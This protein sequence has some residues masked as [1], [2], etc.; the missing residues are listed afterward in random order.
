MVTDEDTGM[1]MIAPS[2]SAS[3]VGDPG[4]TSSQL[5]IIIA[6]GYDGPLC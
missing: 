1:N 4:T 3:F 5:H 2:R 6:L